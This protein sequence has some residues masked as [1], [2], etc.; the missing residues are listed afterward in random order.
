M[1]KET[2]AAGGTQTDTWTRNL[3]G[4]YSP[5]RRS[6]RIA[7]F[8]LTT[9]PT[10]PPAATKAKDSKPLRDPIH[11]CSVSLLKQTGALKDALFICAV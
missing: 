6:R 7:P 8:P 9:G 3:R 4:E 11:A 1:Q 10:T 5:V 2:A